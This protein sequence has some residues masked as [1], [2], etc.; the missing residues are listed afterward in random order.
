MGLCGAEKRVGFGPSGLLCLPASM[1]LSD[2]SVGFVLGG[3]LSWEGGG[4]VMEEWIA[5]L[6]FGEGEHLG[7]AHCA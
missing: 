4:G 2:T 1:K 5:S 7:Q 3:V 6:R